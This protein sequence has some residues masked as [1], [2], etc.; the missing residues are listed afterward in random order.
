[1]NTVTTSFCFRGLF[2]DALIIKAIQRRKVAWS[3]NSGELER[4]WKEEVVAQ[5]RY[6]HGIYLTG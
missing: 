1:V 2:K 5:S 3:M 4:F 6:Y